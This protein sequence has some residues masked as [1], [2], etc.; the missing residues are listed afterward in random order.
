MTSKSFKLKNTGLCSWIVKNC[1]KKNI[2]YATSIQQTIIPSIISG[3]DSL[4]FSRTGT[5]KTLSFILPLIHIHYLNPQNCFISI[6]V[7]TK[8]LG[9][10]IYQTYNLLSKGGKIFGVFIDKK[11]TQF[12]FNIHI[13]CTSHSSRPR[14]SKFGTI[15]SMC[16]KLGNKLRGAVNLVQN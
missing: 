9:I 10:Q 14:C 16:S 8:E 13:A 1:E 4:L 12:I 6:L 15:L 7:P 11:T 2:I 3:K 5:G